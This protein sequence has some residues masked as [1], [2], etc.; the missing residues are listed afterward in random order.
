MF[1][2]NDLFDLTKEGAFDSLQEFKDFTE[3]AS[4]EDIYS[5]LKAGAFESPEQLNSLIKKK[6]FRT[7]LQRMVYWNLPQL[8]L[9][10][11][12]QL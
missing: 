5:I 3:V 2:V 10:Q 8:R 4:I 7:Q 1:E 6:T 9:R 11:H 12:H